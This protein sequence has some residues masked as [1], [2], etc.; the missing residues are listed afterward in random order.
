VGRVLEAPPGSGL[1]PGDWVVGIVRR[2][3]P[4]PCP[5]C[6]IGEWDMCSNGRYTER[7][8]KGLH[9]FASER[10]LLEPRYAVKVDEGL[11][12]LA[13]LLEPASVVAKAWEHI[14]RIGARALFRPETVLVT[15]AGPIGLLA[16][17]M[18]RQRGLEVHV[19][20]L[21]Q[22]G[23]KPE[24][25]RALGATYHDG[26]L[27]RLCAAAD[28]VLECS[29]A[30]SVIFTAIEAGRANAIVCLT[31]VSSGGATLPVDVGALNRELVLEN[32]VVFG[33]VNA[34][35]RHYDAA[36]DAL[37]GSNRGWL[38]GLITRRVP[39]H[40]WT[41]AFEKQPTDVKATIVFPG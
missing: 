27:E 24:L 20:D 8:I 4:M 26:G 29:G 15:G 1:A 39:L 35:R 13:V 21:V 30:P 34:N 9:G 6:A 33:S 16:A 31:G 23:P 2:P 10:F 38:R 36:L 3:D 12:E 19:I 18:G 41:D 40:R 37:T 5:H 17:L 7:G 25:V 14:E 32:A 11:G 22:E 28:I